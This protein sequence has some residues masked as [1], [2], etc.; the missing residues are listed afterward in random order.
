MGSRDGARRRR[1]GPG[2]SPPSRLRGTIRNVD[3][4]EAALGPRPGPGARLAKRAIAAVIPLEEG[5][6]GVAEDDTVAG[7]PEPTG[8]A[9]R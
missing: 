7:E 2:A 8:Q 4:D 5:E 3:E 6:T 1:A 9:Q